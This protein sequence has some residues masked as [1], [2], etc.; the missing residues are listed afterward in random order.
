LGLVELRRPEQAEQ[1]HHLHQIVEGFWA[2]ASVVDSDGRDQSAVV[3]HPLV[4]LLK[5]PA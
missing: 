4:A 3:V 2:T 5:G 1:A